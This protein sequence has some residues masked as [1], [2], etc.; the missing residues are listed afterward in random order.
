[1]DGRLND[2]EAVT[3]LVSLGIT[4]S[5]RLLNLMHHRLT[6]MDKHLGIDFKTFVSVVRS[7]LKEQPVRIRDINQLGHFL[8]EHGGAHTSSPRS[9]SSSTSFSKSTAWKLKPRDEKEHIKVSKKEL[10]RV[11]CELPTA[12]HS[13]LTAREAHIVFSSLGIT[14]PTAASPGTKPMLR[15]RMHGS[16]D[17]VNDGVT[18]AKGAHEGRSLARDSPRSQAEVDIWE[19]VDELSGGYVKFE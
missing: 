16:T 6:L 8:E 15:K 5:R 10:W 19:I 2:Y 11:L 12:G 13:E 4:P 7:I 18:S 3:A 9:P 14:A 17:G 1:M